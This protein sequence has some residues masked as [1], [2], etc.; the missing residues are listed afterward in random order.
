M[1]I[2]DEIL[3]CNRDIVDMEISHTPDG[4]TCI[5]FMVTTNSHAEIFLTKT[6]LEKLLNLI[7]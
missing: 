6:Q 1:N 4:E 7:K 3:E 5:S 2:V